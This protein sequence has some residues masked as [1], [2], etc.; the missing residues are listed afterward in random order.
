[1][2]T[3]DISKHDTDKFYIFFD[4]KC[5]FCNYWV[6]WLLNK[7][8]KDRFL[9]SPLQSALGQKFLEDRKL[10]TE[11]LDTLYLWKPKEYYL[12][13]SQ[14]ILK[15]AKILGGSYAIL[16][17]INF[18]PNSLTDFIYKKISKKRNSLVAHCPAPT[19][20]MKRKIIE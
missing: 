2:N 1:M 11:N 5:A 14:A 10:D 12:K 3:K 15:I 18:L 9:F 20:K 4:G 6:Q 8:K 17:R 13:E 16:A 19:E 7:D